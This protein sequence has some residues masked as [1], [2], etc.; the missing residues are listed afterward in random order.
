[1]IGWAPHYLVDDLTAAMAEAPG[2]YEAHVVR[3]NPVPAPSRQR[4]LVE[5]RSYWDAH[6]PMSGPDFHPLV[7]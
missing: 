7:D 6:E 2:K 3:V 1:M 5:M 4:V